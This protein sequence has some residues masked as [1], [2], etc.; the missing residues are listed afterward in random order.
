MQTSIFLA[1]LIGPVMLAAA[2]SMIINRDGQ[3]AMAKDFLD[4]PPLIYISGVLVML[5]GLAMVLYHNVW[6]ADWRVIIT[7]L[8]WM[9]T[10]GGAI[11]ILCPS[12]VKKMGAAMI[13]K[14]MAMTI[15]SLVWLVIAVVL[16][17]FGYFGYFA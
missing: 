16:L 1:Q 11:R 10:I 5:A 6:V 12:A 9:A 3:R 15:G 8:G 14:P 2:V 13:D 7:L 17:Y 4:S